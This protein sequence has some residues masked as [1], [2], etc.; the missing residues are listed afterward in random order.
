MPSVR[1]RFRTP[2]LVL[3][4]VWGLSAPVAAPAE[5][6]CPD[7]PPPAAG[8]PTYLAPRRPPA[9]DEP[10]HVRAEQVQAEKD[11]VS[12]FSG[13]VE[14]TRGTERLTAERLTYDQ[15]T[16][17][18]Q[19]FGD[20]T[21]KNE[22]GDSFRTDALDL[23]LPTHTGTAGP[24]R[25][26]LGRND[27]RGD[28]QE[29]HFEGH[30][31][32]R[33]NRVR[34]TTCAQD[35]D[36][37]FLKIRELELDTAEDIGTAYHATVDFL[38]VPIFYLPYMNFPISDKRK[39]GFLIPRFGHS[40]KLGYE[41]SVPYYFNL[42]P[43]Y[44][45]TVTPRVL[46]KR[47]VQL[48]NQFRYLTYGSEGKVEFEILPHDDK[49]GD[50][51]AAGSFLHKHTFSPLWSG[52]VDLRGVSDKDYLQDFGDRLGITAQTHLPQNAEINYRG[53]LWNFSGRLADYQTVDKAIAPGDRPYAR[54]PQL[55]LTANAPALDNA[56]RYHFESEWVNFHRDVGVTG[57]RL[58]LAPGVSYPL[59]ASYGFLV[60]RVGAR[61]IQ[62]DLSGAAEETPALARGS[63]SLDSGLIFE[64]DTGWGDRPFVQ[65]LEPRLFYVYVPPKNQD[66]L[67]NFDSGIPDFSFANL[68][69]ENRLVGGDRI[70]DMNQVTTAVTT[71][72]LDETDGT[73][74]LRLSLGRIYYFDDQDVNIP[75]GTGQRRASDLAGEADVWLV[76][77][78]HVR[79]DIQW[80]TD[81]D[82]TQKRNLYLQYHPEK[83]K[84]LNL[85]HRY[86]RDQLEQMDVS[87]EWPLTGRWTLRARSLFSLKE[88]RNVESYAGV[89]YNA[90]CWAL[91]A[92]VSRRLSETE[93][94]NAL[95]LELEL[96]G[97]SK[98]GGVPDSPLKQGL[99]SFPLKPPLAP[100]PGKP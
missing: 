99:F 10:T 66:G 16:D 80:N 98:L 88:E 46:T 7:K 91:R 43:N 38:G 23:A 15:A 63:V 8:M 100:E 37:W 68:F 4:A 31:H 27:A 22:D 44:D 60:P 86:L 90:C 89:E 65:T 20:V 92:L 78:W 41:L 52:N 55:A 82:T 19:A 12:E 26:T 32:T 93:Q 30:N 70:A 85:G 21:L 28:A 94:V 74:R 58:N 67:P 39:S 48:Q 47:G 97:L 54:L 72:F 61:Y 77:N 53:M 87:T 6:L 95:L 45:A 5:T 51:R 36:D 29:V 17:R 71:R 1:R 73:E 83:N 59:V 34:Y 42:A 9:V 96:T 81:T 3:A 14:V 35:R 2:A 13:A 50:D 75:A 18:I 76:G 24:S 25:F 62:Y 79:G 84:I 33:L 64:R 69:R 49:A 56:P 40:D 11:G 57:T